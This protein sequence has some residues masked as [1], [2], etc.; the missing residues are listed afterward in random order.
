MCRAGRHVVA[1]WR[2]CSICPASQLWDAAI[3]LAAGIAEAIGGGGV[4]VITLS[5]IIVGGFFSALLTLAEYVADPQS[6]LPTIVYWLLGSFVGADRAKLEI[7]LVTTLTTGA[8]ILALRWR[9]NLLSLGDT[10]AAALGLRP[11]RLRWIILALVALIVAAQVSVSGIIGWVG[12]I[13]PHM[14]RMLVGPDHRMLLPAS[15]VIGAGFLLAVDNLARSIASQELP[16]G[17]MTALIGTPA[18]A[19]LLWRTHRSG[20]REQ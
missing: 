13:V 19:V 6:T 5:G 7:M 9:I 16:I 14:A 10:D 8:A 20:W 12:L 11:G 2:F 18:F 15:A 1:F 3:G 17:L 4:L